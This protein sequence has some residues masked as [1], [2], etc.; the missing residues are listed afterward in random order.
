[1]VGIW[2]M[3]PTKNYAMRAVSVTQNGKVERPE[4]ERLTVLIQEK[5]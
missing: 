3:L 2:Q 4:N 5:D 1:M